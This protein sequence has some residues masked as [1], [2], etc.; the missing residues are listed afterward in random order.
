[1]R[2]PS[3]SASLISCV[4]MTMVFPSRCC[5]ARNSRRI[6][7]RVS[8]SSAPKGLVHQQNRRI[9]GERARHSHSLALAAGKLVRIAPQEL[10][11]IE[12]DERQ[13]F[14]HARADALRR[15]AFEARHQRDVLLDGVVRKQPGLLNHVADVAAQR[16]RVPVERRAA[17]DEHLAALGSSRRLISLSAVVF[18]APLRPS[19]T[20]VSPRRTVKLTL[21]SSTWPSGS[22]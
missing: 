10:R 2:V 5:S 3:S 20:S 13:Q 21:C 16:D 12:A 8:G 14:L 17:F 4:T 18:P 7:T 1:M 9:G 19:R 15:P 11:R 22:R 6:S